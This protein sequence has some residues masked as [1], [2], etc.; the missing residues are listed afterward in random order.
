[1]NIKNGETTT[2]TVHLEPVEELAFER[3]PAEQART[4]GQACTEPEFLKVQFPRY[5]F[6]NEQEWTALWASLKLTAPPVDFQKWRAVALITRNSWEL[7]GPP[8]TRRITYNP[9]GK[10]TRIRRDSSKIR[11]EILMPIET[12]TAEFIL[13][14]PR[15]G[16]VTFR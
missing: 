5:S 6:D 9:T 13:I 14:P 4:F 16:D 10:V 2:A 7:G 3:L 12:C 1:M 15:P 11:A 8:V